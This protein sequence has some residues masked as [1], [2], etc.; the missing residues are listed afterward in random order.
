M[1]GLCSGKDSPNNPFEI[2]FPYDTK[3]Y[4]GSFKFDIPGKY[5]D[6]FWKYFRQI[7]SGAPR[8]SR[9]LKNY[10]HKAKKRYQNLGFNK[11]DSMPHMWGELVCPKNKDFI[12]GLSS[13]SF[14]RTAATI[15]ADYGVDMVNLKRMGRWKS[16]ICVEGYLANSKVVKKGRIQNL[17]N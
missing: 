17:E 15:L 3:T 11:L 10:N 2:Q 1:K 9:F 5:R 12:N 14:R 16:D 13:Y 4:K 8:D 7:K 6:T